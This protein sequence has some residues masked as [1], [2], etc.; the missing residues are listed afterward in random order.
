MVAF[1]PLSLPFVII[2]LSFFLGDDDFRRGDKSSNL[3]EDDDDV[4]VFVTR[5]SRLSLLQLPEEEDD[6][7]GVTEA[8]TSP[9]VDDANG[10][11]NN[12][13]ILRF[14]FGVD[15]DGCSFRPVVC[16]S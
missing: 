7:E 5:P 2:F 14:D 13:I 4:G 6:D 16:P 12:D 15:D 9:G 11:R 8:A 10:E 3:L 1:L